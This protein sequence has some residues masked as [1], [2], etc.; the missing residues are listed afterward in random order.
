MATVWVLIV[1]LTV[2][3]T[4]SVCPFNCMAHTANRKP[5]TYNGLHLKI[6]AT[7]RARMYCKPLFLS[8]SPRGK[9]QFTGSKS[10]SRRMKPFN[11]KWANMVHTKSDFLVIVG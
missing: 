10:M 1:I 9:S 6:H 4:L 7:E 3:I 2:W 11:S 5:V 8:S